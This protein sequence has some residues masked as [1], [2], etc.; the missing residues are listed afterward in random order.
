LKINDW[1]VAKKKSHD[2]LLSSGGAIAPHQLF[3]GILL[4]EMQYPPYYKRKAGP[5]KVPKKEILPSKEISP[6]VR[7]QSFSCQ[8]AHPCL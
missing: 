7:I 2:P 5:K 4:F 8:P 1:Q 6:W 3:F